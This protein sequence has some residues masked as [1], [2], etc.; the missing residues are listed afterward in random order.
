MQGKLCSDKDIEFFEIL[1]RFFS[2]QFYNNLYKE[3]NLRR[4]A[5]TDARS[6]T[7]FIVMSYYNIMKLLSPEKEMIQE[8]ITILS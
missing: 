5:S 3:S 7:D 1:S 2:N 6:M 4:N 8:N